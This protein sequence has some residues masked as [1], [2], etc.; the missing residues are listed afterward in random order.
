MQLSEG[1]RLSDYV[2][3]LISLHE[4]FVD[5]VRLLHEMEGVTWSNDWIDEHWPDDSI[6]YAENHIAWALKF[7]TDTLHRSRF[8]DSKRSWESHFRVAYDPFPPSAALLLRIIAAAVT[9]NRFLLG[10][11]ALL[12][13]PRYDDWDMNPLWSAR[14]PHSNRRGFVRPDTR[15][16]LTNDAWT[17]VPILESLIGAA[18]PGVTF[19][20]LGSGRT[21]PTTTVWRGDARLLNWLHRA[22]DVLYLVKVPRGARRCGIPGSFRDTRF[23][24]QPTS[25]FRQY[26]VAQA[27]MGYEWPWYHPVPEGGVLRTTNEPAPIQVEQRASRVWACDG[28]GEPWGGLGD[29]EALNSGNPA[30][31]WYYRFEG[32][33]YTPLSRGIPLPPLDRRHV[34][35]R[36]YA[37]LE[38]DVYA[39]GEW[40][41]HLYRRYAEVEQS[42]Y[43]STLSD[44]DTWG[45]VKDS[46]EYWEWT[47]RMY[48]HYSAYIPITFCIESS[49]E[50]YEFELPPGGDVTETLTFTVPEVRLFFRGAPPPVTP[51]PYN[52]NRD[53]D[54]IGT[55]IQGPPDGYSRV[56]DRK[57]SFMNVVQEPLPDVFVDIRDRLTHE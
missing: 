4:R 16:E 51:Y 48:H 34:V 47:V 43:R 30:H 26:N 29:G 46:V 53:W 12:P 28:D 9:S 24:Y 44:M 57:A 56:A 31:G 49:A 40:W 19:A 7:D 23:A 1:A 18:L 17:R 32:D 15:A 10:T 20:P 35:W 13:F 41:A 14:A 55:K 36:Q 37:L 33:G 42:W 11:S 21:V 38:D 39:G 54:L 5:R 50:S 6:Y 27:A 3:S 22:M 25:T 2:E 52:A 8:D 45:D